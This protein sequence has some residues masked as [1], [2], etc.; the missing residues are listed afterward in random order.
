MEGAAYAQLLKL[1]RSH[2]VNIG[3]GTGMEGAT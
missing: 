1:L 3:K 2:E